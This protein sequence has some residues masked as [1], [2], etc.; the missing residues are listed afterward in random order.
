MQLS[1]TEYAKRLG[2]TRSAVLLQIKEK[3]IINQ[4]KKSHEYS[5]SNS[6]IRT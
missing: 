2:V 4:N 6:R 1:V 5:R 3:Q